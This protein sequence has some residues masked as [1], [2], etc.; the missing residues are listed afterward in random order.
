MTSRLRRRWDLL[1]DGRER[2]ATLVV[3]AMLLLVLMGAAAMSVDFGWLF[4]NARRTQQ[5]ADAAALAGVVYLPDDEPTAV[6]TA[7]SVAA[8]NEYIDDSLG[9]DSQVT[10]AKVVANARQLQVT[11]ERPVETF[12]MRAFGIDTITIEKQAIAEYVLPLPL[13][14]P[15]SCFGNNPHDDNSGCS[16]STPN[17]WGNIHGA[18]TGRGMG[19]LYSSRC[20]SSQTGNPNCNGQPN[21]DFRSGG[22]LYAVEM[23]AGMSDLVVELYDPEFHVGG[24]DTV[25]NG[26]N[27][28]SGGDPG[29]TVAFRLFGPDPTPLD[30]ADNVLL[31]EMVYA[32]EAAYPAGTTL[33]DI[34]WETMCGTSFDEGSGVY[35]LQIQVLDPAPATNARGLN[36]FSIQATATGGNPRIYGL[37]DMSIYANVNAGLTEFYLAEVEAIHA[38]KELILNLWDPG[39]AAGNHSVTILDPFGN[40]PACHIETTIPSSADLATCTIATSSSVYNNRGVEITIELDPGYA[41]NGTN[42]WWKVRYDYPAQATDTTTWSARIDGNPVRLVE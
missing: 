31:C 8:T 25:L 40:P 9:G 39:D 30:I 28:Q 19:D 42:C 17:F 35:P 27:P 20:L 3:G 38:G 16:T 4:L 34:P 12:F 13:G 18:Y 24:G 6:S 37:G 22:Y 7:V 5:A 36:R 29:Q 2:G 41:C 32:P 33:V 14:S 23:G 21:P 1:V 26:D 11:V 15:E 10:A